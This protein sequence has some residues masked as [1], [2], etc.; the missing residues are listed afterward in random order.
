MAT[1]RLKGEK[2][3]MDTSP[4]PQEDDQMSV[5]SDVVD[6][7]QVADAHAPPIAIST[8]SSA[9]VLYVGWS[10][11]A[12]TVSC[13]LL[14]LNNNSG[15]WC[16]PGGLIDGSESPVAAALREFCEE[17]LGL[18][19]IDALVHSAKLLS[20]TNSDNWHGPFALHDVRASY[21]ARIRAPPR[22]RGSY[23]RTRLVQPNRPVR[24]SY[25]ASYEPR[26]AEVILLSCT[27]LVYEPRTPPLATHPHPQHSQPV[28]AAPS[29]YQAPTH[30]P[31]NP[32]TLLQ[33]TTKV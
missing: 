30:Q 3:A 7:P 8:A 19:G 24:G 27:R 20:L 6:A 31:T 33:T 22:I 21:T 18:E 1:A 16:T 28:S 9:C 11:V 26:T 5:D 32:P 25:G 12:S 14:R 10:Y 2:D 4:S 15:L 17:L 29:T 13:V 23:A